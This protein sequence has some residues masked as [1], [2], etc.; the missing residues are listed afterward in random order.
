MTKIKIF[1]LSKMIFGSFLYAAGICSFLNPAD[2]APGGASGTSII[3]NH[4]FGLPIGTMSILINIP[5]LYFGFR[6]LDKSLIIKTVF[7]LL[8]TSFVI[9]FVA[10]PLFP[11]YAG[12]RL[13]ASVFGGILFGTG[14]GIIFS[15]GFTTG[16]TDIVSMLLRLKFPHVRIGI[17]ILI[18]DFFVIAASVIFFGEIETGFYGIITL[19]FSGKVVDFFVYYGDSSRLAFII[20]DKAQDLS[21]AI[22]KKLGRGVTIINAEGAFTGNERK[23]LLCAVRHREFANLKNLVFDTDEKAFLT[24]AVSD[25]IFGEG[26]FRKQLF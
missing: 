18:V 8:F 24:S 6:K 23:I 19:F 10:T 7:A 21:H 26:F 15:S 4:L 13:L 25:G 20:T 2:I 12:D 3:L 5:I 17:A 1:N 16:G 11:V 22:I 9:D 14:L